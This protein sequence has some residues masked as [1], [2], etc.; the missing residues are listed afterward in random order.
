MGFRRDTGYERRGVGGDRPCGYAMVVLV[1]GLTGGLWPSPASAQPVPG[2]GSTEAPAATLPQGSRGFGAQIQLMNSGLGLG[3]YWSAQLAPDVT[4]VA[5][6]SISGVRDGREVSFFNRFGGREIPDKANYVLQVPLQA[7]VERRLLS[8]R[9]ED[10]F[11]PFV[12]A[13]TGPALL[14]KSPYFRDDNGNGKLD[15]GETV[16]GSLYS[17]P[18][19]SPAFGWSTTVSIGAH[20]G[21]MSGTIQSLRFGYTVTWFFEE[22]AL[23]VP[24]IRKPATWVGSPTI[25]LTFGRLY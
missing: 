24:S 15:S 2:S 21:S 8:S 10:H 19:G 12:G 1:L 4:F 13:I 18:R 9:I 7:G 6:L 5:E 20:F 3:G 14:W 22:I 11:R 17:I 23:L 16:Y 25:R